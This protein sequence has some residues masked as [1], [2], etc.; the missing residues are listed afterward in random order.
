MSG[1]WTS[2]SISGGVPSNVPINFVTNSG[3]AISAL[4][5]INIFGVGGVSTS[6]SGNTVDIS[7]SATGVTWT[8][9]AGSFAAA[10]NNGYFCDA[11]L[12]ATLPALATQGQTISFICTTG[13]PVTIQADVT[14]FIA[15]G[16]ETSTLGGTAVSTALGDN[17]ILVYKSATSTWWA[18]E[19]DAT[20]LLN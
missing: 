18:V 1:Y 7:V 14:Q 3:T 16:A 9:E 2:G 11:V 8:D 10:V 15:I 12:T 19:A 13:G 5:T 17:L 20:W 4:N 6:G